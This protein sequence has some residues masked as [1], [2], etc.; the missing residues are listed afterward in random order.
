MPIPSVPL[1]KTAA[2]LKN[3]TKAKIE[4]TLSSLS[5][6]VKTDAEF[7]TLL[8]DWVSDVNKTL[9]DKLASTAK[10]GRSFYIVES[11]IFYNPGK[12]SNGDLKHNGNSLYFE[13]VFREYLLS[14]HKPNFSVGSG[15]EVKPIGPFVPRDITD[16]PALPQNVV[17]RYKISWN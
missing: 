2:E 10:S 9:D 13:H 7:T 17:L 5:K 4:A 1:P 3:L 12:K 6:Y 8:S 14:C 15:I 11:P 16:V